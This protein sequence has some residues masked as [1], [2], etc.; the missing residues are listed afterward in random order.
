MSIAILTRDIERSLN[1]ITEDIFWNI[2]GRRQV[3]GKSNL[4]EAFRKLAKRETTRIAIFHVISNG[5]A[6]AVSGCVKLNSGRSIESCDMFEFTSAK[7]ARV[8]T[9]TSYLIARK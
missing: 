1:G 7:G 2:V 4:I 3:A 6:G 8:R 9:I 5:K